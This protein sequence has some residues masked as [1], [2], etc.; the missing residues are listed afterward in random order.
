MNKGPDDVKALRKEA[1]ALNKLGK[2]R[3]ALAKYRPA[4]AALQKMGD[5]VNVV[6]VHLLMVRC[7]DVLHEVSSRS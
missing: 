7:H 2:S 3:A 4:L 1:M 6:D 5:D